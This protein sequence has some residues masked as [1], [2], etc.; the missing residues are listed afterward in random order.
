VG[1]GW[2]KKRKLEY[3]K[4]E[5]GVISS[6][7]HEIPRDGW[8]SRVGGGNSKKAITEVKECGR[9]RKVK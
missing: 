6:G 7:H 5:V 2:G 1:G 4:K 8:A 3:E 9:K